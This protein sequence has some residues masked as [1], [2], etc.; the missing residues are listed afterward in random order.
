VEAQEA[1]AGSQ[2]YHHHHQERLCPESRTNGMPHPLPECLALD[3]VLALDP[4]GLDGRS[5]IGGVR[6]RGCPGTAVARSAA[7]R[8]SRDNAH[9]VGATG[10][11]D[12]LHGVL[13]LTDKE[14]NHIKL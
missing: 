14:I 11:E 6:P 7:R 12:H 3:L 5:Q 4:Q 1:E 8:C 10:H 9:M 2:N 13:D